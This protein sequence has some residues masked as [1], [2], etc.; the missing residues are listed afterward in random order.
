MLVWQQEAVES[1]R[2]IRSSRV[3]RAS[4]LLV[5]P[6]CALLADDI[7]AAQLNDRLAMQRVRKHIDRD[8]ASRLKWFRAA[9]GRAK[10]SYILCK[11]IRIARDVHE[12]GYLRMRPQS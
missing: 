3:I 6:T 7:S 2:S 5:I 11:R 9:G 4:V 8:S 10:H 1:P 12:A